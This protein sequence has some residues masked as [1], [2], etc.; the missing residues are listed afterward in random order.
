M[1][2]A[3][4]TIKWDNTVTG[5][6]ALPNATQFIAGVLNGTTSSTSLWINFGGYL[7]TMADAF[8]FTAQADTPAPNSSAVPLL[9]SGG[10]DQLY[11]RIS[12]QVNT[13]FAAAGDLKFTV[14]ATQDITAASPVTY[15]IG[16][17]VA[18]IAA[19]YGAVAATVTSVS[20]TV[21]T[22]TAHGFSV[23]DYV[24]LTT[25]GGLTIAAQTPPAGSVYQVLSV[26]SANTFTIGL[27]PGSLYSGATT[28]QTTALA[29][30]GTISGTV[31]KRAT[32]GRIASVPLAP[33]FAGSLRLNTVCNSSGAGS[34]IITSA[35]VAY[36]RDSAAIG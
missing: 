18:P 9:H 17:T 26:P 27:G 34:A 7:Q 16:Q 35:S 21:A 29:L 36:G 3:K 15:V 33:N 6:K 19:S 8:N 20:G 28:Y 10:R 2:D 24:Q 31:F 22:A 25:V 12:Y 5:V 32:A 13:A 23:G 4:L 11:M 1:R 30:A 14:E